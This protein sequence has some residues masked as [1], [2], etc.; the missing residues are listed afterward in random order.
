MHVRWG[1]V[2][3]E[4]ELKGRAHKQASKRSAL[5]SQVSTLAEHREL[6]IAAAPGTAGG[7]LRAGGAAGIRA[8]GLKQVA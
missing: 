1:G 6:G 4:P 5:R 3:S 7:L 8:R 2:C